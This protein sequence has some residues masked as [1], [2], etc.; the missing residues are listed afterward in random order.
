MLAAGAGSQVQRRPMLHWR[1]EATRLV[2]APH[3]SLRLQQLIWAS[4][5]DSWIWE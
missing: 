5:A 2:F 4:L 1:D 3:W